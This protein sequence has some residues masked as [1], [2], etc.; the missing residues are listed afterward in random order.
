[1]HRQ[2][3]KSQTGCHPPAQ[4]KPKGCRLG[5]GPRTAIPCSAIPCS[6]I[7]NFPPAELTTA[8]NGKEQAQPKPAH[9]R[10][11]CNFHLQVIRSHHYRQGNTGG[12]APRAPSTESGLDKPQLLEG[13]MHDG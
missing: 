3:A 7:P 9:S 1:M 13:C 5:T 12:Q 11:P 2:D 8:G 4:G 6:A 10:T